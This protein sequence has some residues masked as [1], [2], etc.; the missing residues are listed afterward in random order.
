MKDSAVSSVRLLREGESYSRARF[1]PRTSI[2]PEKIRDAKRRLLNQLTKVVS[3][4]G[5]GP[6]KLYTIHAF[7]EHYDV[8]VA[9]VIVKGE[10]DL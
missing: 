6:C 7:T 10:E 2:T 4:A 5:A 8:I 1:I 3:R 9:G